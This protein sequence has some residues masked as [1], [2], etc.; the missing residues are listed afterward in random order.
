MFWRGK[1]CIS[2]AE[3]V[4]TASVFVTFMIRLMGSLSPRPHQ[5]SLSL[6]SIPCFLS[7]E[8][9]FLSISRRDLGLHH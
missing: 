3:I 4:V 7:K 2:N 8:K 1:M 5:A 6:A 9:E